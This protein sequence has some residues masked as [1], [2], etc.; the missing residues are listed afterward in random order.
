[1]FEKWEEKMVELFNLPTE[2]VSQ[3]LEVWV[4]K[5]KPL[6]D[7]FSSNAELSLRDAAQPLTKFSD[8]IFKVLQDRI[9][10]IKEIAETRSSDLQAILHNSRNFDYT[11]TADTWVVV[12]LP[13]I[14]ASLSDLLMRTRVKITVVTPK[15]DSA[16]VDQA[17]Q[18]RNTIR[19]T[20]AADIDE[21]SD[22]RILKK[23]EGEGRVTLRNYQKRDLY[24]CIRDSEEIVFGY[25]QE[26]QEA[27]G[28][29]SSTPSIVE[30]LEDRLNETVIRNSKV[31]QL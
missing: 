4:D 28:I 24:A 10:F 2:N 3:F 27:V 25:I 19:V 15:L 9:K 11:K 18:L 31:M 12:G 1:M 26:D 16:I 17:K 7:K 8:E 6:I 20:F 23:L 29:R 30:L 5:T 13:S 22:R 14:Y 21:K